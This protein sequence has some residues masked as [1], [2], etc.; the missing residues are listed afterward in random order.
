MSM[1]FLFSEHNV[2]PLIENVWS[3]LVPL[4]PEKQILIEGKAFSRCDE[5]WLTEAFQNLLKNACEY[6]AAN[7][8]ITIIL[9]QT[10]RAFFCMVEDNGGREIG[11]AHV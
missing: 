2:R 7:G 6:T 11:R 8:N 10:D 5:K 3:R 4:W 9:E 1:N